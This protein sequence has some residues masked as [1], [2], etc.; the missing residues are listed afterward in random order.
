MLTWFVLKEHL[1]LFPTFPLPTSVP[2]VTRTSSS[3]NSWVLAFWHPNQGNW[4]VGFV[5]LVGCCCC[6]FCLFF[7]FA[8]LLILL[9]IVVAKPCAIQH[10]AMCS[11][12]TAQCSTLWWLL[13]STL[14]GHTG[15]VS[16]YVS[17]HNSNRM[18]DGHTW[19]SSYH[20]FLDRT[21]YLKSNFH[22]YILNTH[23]HLLSKK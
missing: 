16:V 7:I 11:L 2:G 4:V 19:L 20:M 13:L 6:Y 22:V 3:N 21:S 17:K 15:E 14:L 10:W 5:C 12:H 1:P 18:A 9:R 23:K 8:V